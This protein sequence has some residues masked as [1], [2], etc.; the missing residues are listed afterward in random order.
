MM[1]TYPFYWGPMSYGMDM[2]NPAVFLNP[3]SYTWGMAPYTY[4][5]CPTPWNPLNFIS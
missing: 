4:G 5:P 3:Y 2:F 1:N